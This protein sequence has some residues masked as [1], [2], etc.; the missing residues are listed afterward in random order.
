MAQTESLANETIGRAVTLLGGAATFKRP[1][2]TA[3]DA[4]EVILSGFPSRAILSLYENVGL[5]RQS[6]SLEKAVG[7]S[8][9]TFQRRKKDATA[10]KLSQEQSG[11]AWKF[12]EILAKATGI[13]GSQEE[14]EAFLERPALGLNQRRPIDLLS[15]PAGIE[16]VEDH[17]ERM[18][19]GVYA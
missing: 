2:A 7:I 3:L 5:I 4:H 18:R 9:R 14:A 10:K 19:Y 17:L 6:D 1:M 11:R 8:L 13:L 15:T 16:L 12:A